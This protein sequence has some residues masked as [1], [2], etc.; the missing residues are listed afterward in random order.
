VAAALALAAKLRGIP[1]Y[2]VMPLSAPAVKKRGVLGYGAQVIDCP[3][4]ESRQPTGTLLSLSFY[5]DACAVWV[6]G[7]H[8][9]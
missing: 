4:V 6:C 1:A 7:V 5:K 2:I 8:V 3:T 9:F